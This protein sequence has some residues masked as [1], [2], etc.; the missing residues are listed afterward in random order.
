MGFFK[1]L[2]TPDDERALVNGCR[3]LVLGNEKKALEHLENDVH[4]AD[5]ANL[6]GFLVLKQKQLEEVNRPGIA[7]GSILR[8]DGVMDSL[9]KCVSGRF[10][11][12][13]S[14]RASIRLGDRP[15]SRSPRRSA[16]HPRPCASGCARPRS[17]ADD[18]PG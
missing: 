7:G 11:W 13:W 8:E 9:G 2:V 14:T 6:A 18:E 4:L 15:S 1:R 17:T 5:G 16:A 3:E 10:V 12:F